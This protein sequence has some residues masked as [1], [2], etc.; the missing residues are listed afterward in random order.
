MSTSGRRFLRSILYIDL[1]TSMSAWASSTHRRL[2]LQLQLHG[3]VPRF[4]TVVNCLI[5]TLSIRLHANNNLDFGL[6]NVTVIKLMSSPSTVSTE[7]SR[8][9]LSSH[10]NYQRTD[11]PFNIFKQVCAPLHACRFFNQST[12]HS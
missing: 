7:I 2:P 9:I 12:A 11:T 3:P 1:G 8:F 5:F 6:S 10:R 4:D